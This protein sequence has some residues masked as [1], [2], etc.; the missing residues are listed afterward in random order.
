MPFT[1]LG[2]VLAVI[3]F[4]AVVLF[5]SLSGGARVVTSTGVTRDVVVASHDIEI[6][7]ALAPTDLTVAK[8]PADSVPVGSVD[9]VDQVKGLVS[10]VKILKG[11]AV[12]SNLVV[13]SPDL[14]SGA[15]DYLPI[16]SGFVL[17]QIPTGELP[18]VGGR[19]QEGDYISMV[20]TISSQGGKYQNT[21]TIY[22]NIHVL[23]VGSVG[24]DQPA[25]SSSAPGGKAPAPAKPTTVA[26]SLSIVVSQCQAEFIKWFL[27]NGSLTLV[28]QSYK[29]YK[30]VDGADA[31]CPAI[32]SAK[33][34]TFQDV[35]AR[36]PGIVSGA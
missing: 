9:K 4:G 32:T 24:S 12:T 16:P 8:M 5:A 13:S 3:G 10:A 6:R 22:T 1:I 7:T 11:Q 20:A 33:G 31:S 23:K 35:V 18:G 14:V 25:Q 2:V 19:I 34:V 30:G 28:L 36:W 27:S 15:H 17:L 29:D 21:R 26:S